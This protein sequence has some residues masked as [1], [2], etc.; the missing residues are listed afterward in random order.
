MNFPNVLNIWK[1]KERNLGQWYNFSEK[2]ELKI[3]KEIGRN[4]KYANYCEWKSNIKKKYAKIT[5]IKFFINFKAYLKR[6]CESYE[7]K[8][9]VLTSLWIPFL[10]LVI[11]FA[12]VLPSVFVGLKQYQDNIQSKIDDT[13]L[14][15]MV[16]YGADL[17]ERITQQKETLQNRNDQ[18]KSSINFV[19]VLLYVIYSTLVIV[20]ISFAIRLKKSL[21]KIAFYKDYINVI[22]KI[23]LDFPKGEDQKINN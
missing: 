10:T 7:Q 11:S 19:F 6:Q 23:I 18:C 15:N 4:K 3:Y 2:T 8:R 20:G 12:L 5:E 9:E 16:E 22:D 14:A 1:K 17:T 13:Y 21:T